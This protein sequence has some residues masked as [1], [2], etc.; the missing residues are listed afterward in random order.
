MS[1][2]SKSEVGNVQYFPCVRER[3][4]GGWRINLNFELE[5]RKY[6][7][8]LSLVARCQQ[9]LGRLSIDILRSMYSL[10]DLTE[11]HCPRNFAYRRGPSQGSFTRRH[12][13]GAL[14][15]ACMMHLASLDA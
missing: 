10:Q 15:N 8:G 13:S 9:P 5:P 1:S 6:T 7:D 4:R 3:E 2:A 14:V 12:P 11:Q